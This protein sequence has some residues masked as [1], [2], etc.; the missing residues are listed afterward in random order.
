MFGVVFG[1]INRDGINIVAVPVP[2]TV[3]E[4]GAVLV[5]SE[6]KKNTTNSK[7]TK[8]QNVTVEV[9][10]VSIYFSNSSQYPANDSNELKNDINSFLLSKSA[11][12]DDAVVDLDMP[13]RISDLIDFATAESP[14]QFREK[15]F[16]SNTLESLLSNI[17]EKSKYYYELKHLL[18][19]PNSLFSNKLSIAKR[20]AKWEPSLHSSL[21]YSETVTIRPIYHLW[22]H[23]RRK[24]IH[25]I[26]IYHE[27][28]YGQ[29]H[30]AKKRSL[31]LP[32]MHHHVHHPPILR[33]VP[34]HMPVLIHPVPPLPLIPPPLPILSP[35]VLQQIL[36]I[37]SD[38]NM[39]RSLVRLN[40]IP[41]MS[42]PLITKIHPP[43]IPIAKQQ[44]QPT[45][46]N[47]FPSLQTYSENNPSAESPNPNHHL[48]PEI[49]T[50][51]NLPIDE[52]I[53]FEGHEKDSLND[54]LVHSV[55][56][57]LN[58]FSITRK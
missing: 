41:I 23:T 50:E 5:S 31:L 54:P 29:K 19:Q 34:H 49:N 15:F 43:L 24:I 35:L 32:H 57:F 18:N 9:P 44:F 1:L 2:G 53:K 14:A 48:I 47:L 40:P 56:S 6:T 12:L 51:E 42:P 10:L 16:E 58:N 26:P 30:S 52:L 21:P 27:L 45:F 8:T 28:V 46:T 33:L 4:K 55:L 22:N 39:A 3:Y 36:H 13:I 20:E 11:N 25:E 37:L 38:P 17:E 7:N